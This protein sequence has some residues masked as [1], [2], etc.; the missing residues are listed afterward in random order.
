MLRDAAIAWIRSHVPDPRIQADFVRHFDGSSQQGR[1]CYLA[2]GPRL[3]TD[4]KPRLVHCF[5]D[6]LFIFELTPAQAR[7]YQLRPDGVMWGT[8]IG[9][10]RVQNV[11]PPPVTISE[12]EI[13][14]SESLPPDHPV[15]A[16]ISY[17]TNGVHLGRTVFRLDY[18]VPGLGR[19]L[20][21]WSYVDVPLAVRGRAQCRFLPLKK[22]NSAAPPAEPVA[23]FLRLCALPDPM[24]KENRQP[25]SN[26]CGTVVTVAR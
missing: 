7:G 3:T 2:I 15:I 11:E 6:N 22:A 16:H 20:T 24:S 19:S 25:I 4:G 9:A 17:D 21:G 18:E 12:Q 8:S 14:K 26:I 10:D 1:N 5:C 23:M 13:E